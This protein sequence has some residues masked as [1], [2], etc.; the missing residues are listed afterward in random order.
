MRGSSRRRSRRRELVSLGS[1]VRRRAFCCLLAPFLSLFEAAPTQGSP[2][3]AILSFGLIAVGAISLLLAVGSGLVLA[4]ANA[5]SYDLYYRSL[6]LSASTERRILV[7]RA[8]VVL[9]AALAAG[10]PSR[11]R[12][13]FRS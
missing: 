9:T 3:S 4:I 7:A 13:S 5:L 10:A 1:A 8:A 12:T 6:H 11:R 2:A